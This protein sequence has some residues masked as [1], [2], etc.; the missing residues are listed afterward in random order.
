MC[1]G[2]TRP[3]WNARSEFCER[4]VVGGRDVRRSIGLSLVGRI[5]G[6]FQIGQ[7]DI[8]DHDLICADICGRFK[9][10]RSGIGH[11]VILINTISA[12]TETSD[13]NA[14]LVKRQTSREKHD[15]ILIGI[16][17][18]RTLR[19]R[20]RQVLRVQREEGARIRSVDSRREQGL[21]PETNRAV[22]DGGL[23]GKA[24]HIGD[25]GTAEIDDVARLGDCDIDAEDGGVGHAVQSENSAVEIC[26]GNGHV[27]AGRRR[28]ANDRP[29]H[30]RRGH[31]LVD[32]RSYI[33]LSQPAGARAGTD[34]IALGRKRPSDRTD[35]VDSSGNSGRNSCR[36]SCLVHKR[37][38]DATD[39][40]DSGRGKLCGGR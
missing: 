16:G 34:K 19:A 39:D 37:E 7:A 22:G 6:E 17:W 20:V 5:A 2:I 31:C 10:L 38:R 28:Q 8:V 27:C 35:D 30:F 1:E 21:R 15:A 14:V 32:D 3:S 18:L 29:G 23:G 12:D 24:R 11:I 25:A 26:D 36:Q 13:E 9:T 40:D 33:R 4:C